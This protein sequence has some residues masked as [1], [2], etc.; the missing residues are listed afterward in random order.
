MD[1]T[2]GAR[3]LR[4]FV[5]SG[6]L[7]QTRLAAELGIKQPSV[8]SWLTGRARPESHLRLAISMIAGIPAGDWETDDER[9]LVE[10][11]RSKHVDPNELAD[12]ALAATEAA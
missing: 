4:E 1:L 7:S 12:E 6:G 9:A 5:E 10:R 2:V 3:K 8:S 11:V